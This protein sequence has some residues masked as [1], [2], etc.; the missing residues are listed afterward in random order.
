MK[1]P[2]L[3]YILYV[4]L[5]G[6][7]SACSPGQDPADSQPEN[8]ASEQQIAL[9][10]YPLSE[11]PGDLVWETNNDDPVFSSAEA[12]KG[13]TFN[14]YITSFP[15]TLRTVGPDAGNQYR[16][17][18]L[19]NQ[20]S[21]TTLH[22]VTGKLIPVMAAE[23]AY[24][25]DMRT[26]YYKLNQ[27]VKWSDGKPV[28]A[29]D[30][31]F[32]LEFMRSEAIVDPWYNNHYTNEV[33]NINKYDDYTI[34]ITGATPKPEIDLHNYYGISPRPRHFHVLDENWVTDYNW[35][36][37]P[38]TGPYFISDLQKGKSITLSRKVDW[39][40]K[41]LR[42]MKNRFNVDKVR[43]S[44]IRDDEI[45]FQHFLKGELDTYLISTPVFW[46]EKTTGELFDNGYIGKVWFY[47][48]IPRSPFGFYLNQ[49][50]NV[51]KDQKVRNAIA[52]SLN[53]DGMINSILRGD[54]QRLQSFHTGHGEYSNTGI[55]A[56]K[57]DIE[58]AETYFAEAGWN[59]RGPDGI[60]T[61]GGD[62]L[63]V[64]V[65]YGSGLHTDKLVYLKEE[66][67][68]SGVE[69]VLEKLDPAA[70]FRKISEKT[71]D[72]MF[73]GFG[74]GLRPAYWEHLHSDNAH[75]NGT[76]NITNTDNP[77][78]DD[79]ILKYRESVNENERQA[80]A[81]KLEQLI[82]DQGA[83]IPAYFA[84]YTRSAYWRWV[85]LPEFH[86][87]KESETLFWPFGD[88]GGFSDFGGLFWIDQNLKEDVLNAK[89]NGRA[90]EPTTII[91][92]T[93]RKN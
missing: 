9:P 1:L 53:I 35:K 38:N 26:V 15:L 34:S 93:Y 73:M 39:W 84:P 69:L 74:V 54:Y 11:L 30:Y 44:V 88:E 63:S 32:A 61:K 83:F 20:M 31:M 57:Y 85:K 4:V 46:H 75:K 21:L 40:A 50:K 67:K 2:R 45:A 49:D 64:R 59:E 10:E 24:S 91:D 60:R 52:H 90:F 23:W 76:N 77:E 66:A 72:I 14:T 17:I 29:D 56:R 3:K 12:T 51:F 33:L 89:S 25:D 47:N 6:L 42:Y 71:Y 70:F 43:I 36:I 87:T 81:R 19:G 48:D 55:K 65:T 18:M 92:E 80:L 78:I 58:V 79:F 28:T 7:L 5:A 41:D 8:L 62:R 22:P 82:H 68:K 27:K 86:G 13:G 37:E 16:G